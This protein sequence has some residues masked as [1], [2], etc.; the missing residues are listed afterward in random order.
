MNKETFSRQKIL[1]QIPYFLIFLILAGSLSRFFQLGQENIW[2]D[3]AFSLKISKDIPGLH[4]KNYLF[5]SNWGDAHPPFYYFILH[6]WVGLFGTGEA[7][8]RG[9][10]AVCGVLVVISTYHV[11][12]KLIDR[13]T[14]II[15]SLLILANPVALYYS[16]EARMYALTSLLILLSAYFFYKSLSN[17]RKRY[18]ILYVLVSTLL[19]Y[20]HYLGILLLGAELFFFLVW[21]SSFRDRKKLKMVILSYLVILCLYIP[22]A[23]NALV[24]LDWQQISWMEPPTLGWGI[25]AITSLLGIEIM[26]LRVTQLIS[27]L[28]SVPTYLIYALLGVIGGLTFTVGLLRSF[29]EKTTFKTLLAVLC[30]V[31]AIMF[32]ISVVQVPI[33]SLRQAS[34]Y[35]PEIALITSIGLVTL[36]G[37]V[38]QRFGLT[39]ANK[40][41][42]WFLVPLLLANLV[43]SYRV[44]TVDTKRN[45]RR[46][47]RKVESIAEDK[48]VVV[49]PSRF[50]VPLGYYQPRGAQIIPIKEGS[51]LLLR[52]LLEDY[53]EF[54]LILREGRSSQ[55]FLASLAEEATVRHQF[56]H[57]G[58]AVYSLRKKSMR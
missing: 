2:L 7:S 47:A 29:W 54:I 50:S 26:H 4:L 39:L 3:E 35:L 11:G 38:C 16:Q 34:V 20:T 1:S 57:Q 58:I 14:A 10:S 48:P 18:S 22:W 31:P 13:K 51:P 24:R 40:V 52:Q 9:L 17:G 25:S 23:P 5:F 42:V 37:K 19:I 8:L 41:L 55:D 36:S 6:F 46:I 27:V 53:Y 30:F 21:F 32:L 49:F 15:S 45:W 56:D 43:G 12:S 33:F 44:Y 28:G